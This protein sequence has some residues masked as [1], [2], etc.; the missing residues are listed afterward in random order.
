MKI[1]WTDEQAKALNAKRTNLL[2]SAAA[3]S[4]KTQVLSGRILRRIIEEKVDITSF[5]IVTFTKA[6]AS[7]MRE[8]IAKNISQA[9]SE[10]PQDSHLKRQLSLIP[11]AHIT[12]I[13]SF[14]LDI[15]QNHFIEAELEPGFR[16]AEEGEV[17]LL[18]AEA[19]QEALSK[20]YENPEF[21]LFTAAYGSQR[22][23]NDI[24][25]LCIRVHDFAESMPFP[26]E[27]LCEKLNE[28]EDTA[29]T[30]TYLIK[31]AK[32]TLQRALE[33]TA[34]AKRM[35]PECDTFNQDMSIISEAINSKTWDDIYY[36]LCIKFERF[37]Y[38]KGG[39][40][41]EAAKEKREEIKDLF[42]KAGTFIPCTEEET[43]SIS[44][45][46]FDAVKNTVLFVQCFEE[47]YQELKRGRGLLDFSDIEHIAI[48]LLTEKTDGEYVKSD[49]AKEISEVFDEIYVDEYQDS[50]RAQELLFSMLSNGNNLFMVGDAKQSIYGFR[51]TSADIFMEK[52]YS[53]SQRDAAKNRKVCLSKNF[54]SRS[55]ILEFVNRIFVELMTKETGGIEYKGE[56]LF[57]GADYPEAP[58]SF[59]KQEINII[60]LSKEDETSIAHE[61]NFASQRIKELIGTPVYDIKTKKTRELRYSDIVVLLRATKNSAAEFEKILTDN[62][63]P[64]YADAGGGF[65]EAPEVETFISLLNVIDNSL[66]DIPLI[67][68]L[69]SPIFCFSEDE[70][71]SIR[72]SEKKVS[73]K[74][75]LEKCAEKDD[76]LAKKCKNVILKIEKW[77]K[78]AKTMAID[79]FIWYLFD[80]TGYMAFVGALPLGEVRMANLKLLFEKARQFEASSFKGLFNFLNYISKVREK[81]DTVSAKVVDESYN[82]VRIMSIHKS[83]GLE[84]PVVILSGCAKRFNRRSTTGKILLH[85]DMG[86]GIECINPKLMVS[87]PSI[88]KKAVADMILREEMA[89]ELRILYVALTRAKEKLIIT[90]SM[91][92]A[93]QTIKKWS[94]DFKIGGEDIY[95]ASCYLELLYKTVSETGLC[96]I[97]I[98]D[99]E[100]KE[101]LEEK[102]KIEISPLIPDEETIKRLDYK[103]ESR[104]CNIPAKLS[105]TELKN[106]MQTEDAASIF[107]EK[108]LREP[109][110]LQSG[111][112]ATDIGNATHKVMQLINIQKT[113]SVSEINEEIEILLAKR[114]IDKE[115][116]ESVSRQNIYNF[117]NSDIGK[118]LKKSEKVFRET[119][120][121]MPLPASVITGDEADREETLIV[122]GIIDCFFLEGDKA[123][124]VDYKTDRN[125]GKETAL[126]RYK[127]QVDIYAAA[128]SKK[129]FLKNL[130][131]CIYLFENNDIIYVE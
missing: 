69:R 49:I 77:R 68:L 66:S 83:K 104:G 19:A 16:I 64:A 93:N 27:W 116:A 90:A 113:N 110:F 20:M 23:D 88:H 120:F 54:R 124:I 122:Q 15:V 114:I 2:V 127:T 13:H 71:V 21:A 58:Q 36:N 86:F 105:V 25:D 12:T 1:N 129:Y 89:E 107:A 84:F 131:K 106:A 101:V 79:E 81:S 65:F 5:L 28:F 7:E 32:A 117:F 44:K 96:D 33:K 111:A 31:R 47:K 62:G 3:G 48:N 43:E 34:A 60:N 8:R 52:F 121:T 4:G 10:N 130:E 73:F 35:F 26:D 37:V 92:N 97:N 14:C 38:P 51:N 118:R 123:V 6:A 75:A 87:Y 78:M 9:L 53:Y 98:T 94:Q 82:V 11:A 115:S 119:P 59:K 108:N 109:A 128:I 95:S 103:Y 112:R 70:L 18:K 63:I 55:E 72:L 56:K 45:I 74:E 61:A 91:K 39:D 40:N 24:S 80:D 67:A 17:T 125:I 46:T 76:A 102:T 57:A 29:K 50:N 99:L 42:E 41:R 85:K 126:K 30:R 100:E 22:N